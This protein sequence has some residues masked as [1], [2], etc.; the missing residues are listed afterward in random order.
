MFSREKDGKTRTG[1]KPHS[2][3]NTYGLED[4]T[5]TSRTTASKPKEESNWLQGV[6]AV[7]KGR[8]RLYQRAGTPQSVKRFHPVSLP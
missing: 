7:V 6:S 1:K 8:V 5:Q 2:N 3:I 4:F